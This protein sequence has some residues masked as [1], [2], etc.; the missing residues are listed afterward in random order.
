MIL[1]DVMQFLR[2]L[3]MNLVVHAES[4][5]LGQEGAGEAG[6]DQETVAKGTLEETLAHQTAGKLV[7]TAS[8]AGR[9]VG[10]G[11]NLGRGKECYI[12]LRLETLERR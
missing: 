11:V 5:D 8:D 10:V 12:L 3:I 1:D 4:D 9:V 7:V 6:G 2:K